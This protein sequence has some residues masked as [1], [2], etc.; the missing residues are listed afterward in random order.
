MSTLL[1]NIEGLLL[2]ER[3]GITLHHPHLVVVVNLMTIDEDNH[4]C[5]TGNAICRLH[6]P[7][8]EDATH[9]TPDTEVMVDPPCHHLRLPPMIDMTEGRMTAMLPIPLH[10]Q[11]GLGHHL[12]GYGK[13]MTEFHRP[14]RN[15]IISVYILLTEHS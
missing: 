11:E 5:L 14:G 10:M 7:N 4:L 13:I 15:L 8:S 3:F 1:G 2:Q 6:P 9:Q 12:Q